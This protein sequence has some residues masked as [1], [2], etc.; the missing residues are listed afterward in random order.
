MIDFKLVSY[1][2]TVSPSKIKKSIFGVRIRLGF[3]TL[4]VVQPIW[5][6]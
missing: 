1:G 6:G 4:D 3:V 5:V 2:F